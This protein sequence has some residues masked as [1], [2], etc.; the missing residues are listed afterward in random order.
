MKPCELTPDERWLYA[1]LYEKLLTRAL[2]VLLPII[3]SIE[4]INF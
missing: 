1:P 3:G 2:I 4:A